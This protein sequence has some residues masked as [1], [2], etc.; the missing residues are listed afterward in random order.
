MDTNTFSL[1]RTVK[2]TF[3][4]IIPAVF[5]AVQLYMPISPGLTSIMKKTSSSGITRM[6]RSRAAGKSV[7]PSFCHATCGVGCPSAAHSKRAFVPVRTVMSRGVF[8]NEGSTVAKQSDK[9]KLVQARFIPIML[10][11][12]HQ[13][14][15][16]FTTVTNSI[17]D[18][19]WADLTRHETKKWLWTINL[20]L[21]LKLTGHVIHVYC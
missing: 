15:R 21:L 7:P 16:A 12:Q 8:T 20:H 9:G 1:P 13:T 3:A 5:L 11:H 17:G 4:E 2:V 6:R 14:N 10:L 19:K 18:G